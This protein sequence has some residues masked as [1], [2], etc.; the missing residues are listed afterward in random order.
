MDAWNILL[1]G[2]GGQGVLVA[3]ELIALG[4]LK[5]GYDVKKSEVHGMAQRGGTV[6]S[7]VRCGRKVFSPLIPAGEADLLI[8]F[9]SLEALRWLGFLRKQG[10]L[11][12]GRQE[13]MP[14][15][16]TSGRMHYPE[17][18]CAS[19]ERRS[20]P[21]E[22]IDALGLARK[23][24][25]VRSINSV[26]VGAASRSFPLPVEIWR[27]VIEERL[28]RKVVDVNLKAFEMGRERVPG[29]R[30]KAKGKR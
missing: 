18:I 30:E 21:T 15:T 11:L 5:A 26:L 8:A 27:E 9:E 16:V 10:R 19:L 25:D 2:V 4:F 7:H 28:P 20:A 6:S 24:G 14:T 12:V 22:V 1:V 23:A 29:K 13:I 3:S 17:D